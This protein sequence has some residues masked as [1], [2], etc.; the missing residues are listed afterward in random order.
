M[1]C[2]EGGSELSMGRLTTDKGVEDMGLYEMAHNCCYI[3]DGTAR[4][5]DF[6]TDID[7][8]EMI[9]NLY[10]AYTGNELQ[11]AEEGFDECILDMLMYDTTEIEGLI[12]LYYRNLWAMANLRER[13]KAYEDIIDEPEKL[14][15][16]D[17]MYLEKCKEINRLKAELGKYKQ[18]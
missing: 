12:A 17:G 5:R 10:F 3:K 2:P 15:V 13:L 14:K 18:L 4:Y 8:R 6:I 9:K 11:K 16:I 1:D 7:T